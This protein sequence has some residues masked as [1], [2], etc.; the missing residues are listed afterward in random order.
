PTRGCPTHGENF[1]RGSS[2]AATTTRRISGSATSTVHTRRRIRASTGPSSIG[3]SPTAS[4]KG[5]TALEIVAHRWAAEVGPAVSPPVVDEP[6]ATDEIL[7]AAELAHLAQDGP[8]Q[9]AVVYGARRDPA[10]VLEG[11]L[12]IAKVGC[13]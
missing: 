3:R 12:P 13:P 8:P 7:E 9:E 4:A 5:S 10:Q 2:R 6:L 11:E 1:M